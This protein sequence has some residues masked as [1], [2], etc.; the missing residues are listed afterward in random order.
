MEATQTISTPEACRITGITYRQIDY[1]IRQGWL[2]PHIRGRG[3]GHPHRLSVMDLRC[4]MA[5]EAVVSAKL[6]GQGEIIRAVAERSRIPEEEGAVVMR[7]RVYP[8]T[9]VVDLIQNGF[10][11]M[12]LIRFTPV[13]V[14][15]TATAL[16]LE[17]PKSLQ[18]SRYE[19]LMAGTT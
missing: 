17:S 6:N 19:A 11:V 13:D 15:E 3:S 8:V 16:E 10:G 1:W 14:L 12:T 18:P 7:G 4:A 2:H 5:I 9:N